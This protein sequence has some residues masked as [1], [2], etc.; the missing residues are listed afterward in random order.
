VWR[1]ELDH[2]PTQTLPWP[3]PKSYTGDPPEEL[4]NVKD[5]DK[6]EFWRYRVTIEMPVGDEA[7]KAKKPEAKS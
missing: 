1:V 5:A 3:V 6:R 4:V 2:A 7:R